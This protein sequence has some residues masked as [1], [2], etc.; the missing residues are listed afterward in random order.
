M[1]QHLERALYEICYA[2]AEFEQARANRHGPGSPAKNVHVAE[3]AD[4]VIV[5]LRLSQW[6]LETA[7]R[8]IRDIDRAAAAPPAMSGRE[9]PAAP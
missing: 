9:P 8:C 2:L 7:L 5:L 1:K 6:A 3:K 4:S